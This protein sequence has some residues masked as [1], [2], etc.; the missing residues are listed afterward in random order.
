MLRVLKP[1]GTARV[2]CPDLDR[3][4]RF[5]QLGQDN[6]KFRRYKTLPEAISNLAQNHAHKSVWNEDLMAEML[7]SVG[8]V[9]IQVVSF[10]QSN[11]PQ[12]GTAD[13]PGHEWQSLYIEARKREDQLSIR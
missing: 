7:A 8:F 10:G 9:D 3:Y 4:L 1:G 6:P 5:E 12:L 11:D 2:V 13:A